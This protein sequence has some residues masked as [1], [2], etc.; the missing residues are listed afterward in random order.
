MPPESHLLRYAAVLIA[1]VLTIA[2]CSRI[3]IAYNTGDFLVKGYAKDYLGLTGAQ[4][5]RWD[6]DLKDALARHRVEELPYLAAFFDRVLTASETG[7]NETN[8]A[9]LTDEFLDLYRRQARFAVALAAPLLVELTPAQRQQLESRFQAEAAEDRTELAEHSSEYQRLKR[10]RRYVKSIED[11]TGSLDTAQQLIVGDVTARMP[12]RQ[13][14]LI[15]YR[16]HKRDQLIELLK[17]G[18]NQQAVEGFMTAWL[19]NFS[20]LPPEI[21][22]AGTE[23]KARI[24]ELFVRLGPSLNAEQRAHLQKRLRSIRDDLLNLQKEPRLAPLTC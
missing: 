14:N 15:D 18:A 12:A 2:G 22:H 24:I 11:W 17:S 23:M 6:P 4:L 21:D 10:A 20:D 16:T 9:C 19:V 13:S 8:M 1:A 3:G 5:G 7:F